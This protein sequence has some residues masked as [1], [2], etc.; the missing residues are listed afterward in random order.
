MNITTVRTSS[1]SVRQIGQ[2]ATKKVGGKDQKV[3]R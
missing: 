1:S 3:D 2:T